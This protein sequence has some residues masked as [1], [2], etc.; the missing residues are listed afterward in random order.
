M[1]IANTTTSAKGNKYPQMMAK[2]GYIDAVKISNTLQG[3]QYYTCTVIKLMT[4]ISKFYSKLICVINNKGSIW[5]SFDKNTNK[6]VAVK[7]INR[8]LHEKSLSNIRINGEKLIIQENILK[9]R[10]ILKY[11]TS[12]NSS[13]TIVKFQKFLRSYVYFVTFS[14]FYT[15]HKYLQNNLNKIEILIIIW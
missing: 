5:K 8:N 13:K 2:V 15:H 10:Q 12:E 11:L 4:D 1:S 3:T 6:Y 9:E 7:I 14:I